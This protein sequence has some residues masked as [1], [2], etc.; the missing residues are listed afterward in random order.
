MKI[1]LEKIFF[2]IFISVLTT[3]AFSAVDSSS[4]KVKFDR[5]SV[6]DDGDPGPHGAGEITFYISLNGR[7]VF[8]KYK[9]VSDRGNNI[10]LLNFSKEIRISGNSRLNI[11]A[12]AI[13]NDKWLMGQNCLGNASHHKLSISGSYTLRCRGDF[14]FDL[15][16]RIDK[17]SK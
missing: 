15:H 1:D 7:K 14:G 6:Y 9:K 3:N 10:V 11:R 17:I 12:C 2:S 4:F 8:N 16:Y 5:I 13:E